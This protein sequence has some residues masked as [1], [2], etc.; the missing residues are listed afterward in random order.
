M[1]CP[2]C[3]STVAE[4]GRYRPQC[5]ASLGGQRMFALDRGFLSAC[6]RTGWRWVFVTGLLLVLVPAL[7]SLLRFV[8]P[9]LP[10]PVIIALGIAFV[11]CVFAGLVLLL[12]SIAIVMVLYQMRPGWPAGK[13]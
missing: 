13:H 1:K 12:L 4:G 11:V 6:R 5:G 7:L 10:E 2:G 8:V 9:P 3:A